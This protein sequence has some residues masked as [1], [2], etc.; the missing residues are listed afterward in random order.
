MLPRRRLRTLTLL[1]LA[2]AFACAWS[3]HPRPAHPHEIEG[4]EAEAG[5]YPNDWFGL[6]RAFPGTTIPQDRWRAA[7]EQTLLE[8]SLSR[9]TLDAG[10]SLVWSEVGPSNIGGRVT[11]IASPPGGGVVYLGTADGGVFRSVND[12][13]DF[14]PVFDAV[15]VPSIG[16]IA[17]S[18]V[19]PNT[20]YVG[21]GE[22]NG[23]VDNY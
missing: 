13:V 4:E 22:A 9:T 15:G 17:V 1:A 21:T 19:D 6:Q 18:P 20:V 8:R 16:A 2:V 23:A 7:V 12:G 10:P 3:D 5:H 14:T 11:A